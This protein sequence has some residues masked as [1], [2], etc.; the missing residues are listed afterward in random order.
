MGLFPP[1]IRAE[2]K[3]FDSF[4]FKIHNVINLVLWLVCDISRERIFFMMQVEMKS[5]SA[6]HF[7]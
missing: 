7:F 5:D 3:E 1:V 6:I 2:S 4:H